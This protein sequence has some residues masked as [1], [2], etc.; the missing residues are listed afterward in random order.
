MS[1]FDNRYGFFTDSGD[2][3]ITDPKTPMPWSHILTNGKFGTVLSQTGSGYSFYQDAQQSLITRWIQDLVHDRYGK[4]LYIKNQDTGEIRSA[5]YKP[6]MAEGEYHIRYSPGLAVYESLFHDYQCSLSLFVP[7]EVDAEIG[8]FT[9][10]N[11]STTPLSLS[12]FTYLEMN[13]GT[14][15]DIHREFHK[16]FFD[17]VYTERLQTL[18]TNKYLWAAGPRHWNDSYPWTVFHGMSAPVHSYDTD[19]R[20]FVGMYGDL[21]DPVAVSNGKCSGSMGRSVDAI[22]ALHTD[23]R[24]QPG[25]EK[26]ITLFTGVGDN[27]SEATAIV[28]KLLDTDPHILQ[29]KTVD[30][31]NALFRRVEVELPP[32]DRDME[33]MINRWLPYQAIAGRIYARTAYYQMG[34]AYGFRDQLQD[35][36]SAL[37]LDPEITRK[38]ILLH[39]NHQRRDGTVQHWWLPL[40]GGF[41]QQRWSD[42]LLWLPLAIAEYI[43][44]TGD[45]SILDVSIP[46]CNEGTASVQEHALVAID[47][48]LG[49]LS[50]RKIPLILDGDW[51][52]GLN[53]LGKNGTG[54]SFWMSEFLFYVI[55][56]VID[57]FDLSSEKRV[58]LQNNALELQEAFN[59]HGWNGKWFDRA[60][61]DNGAVLGG[62][63]D[64]RIFLNPQT[65]AAISGITD[66]SKTEKALAQVKNKLLSDYGPLLFTP[67]LT[68]PDGNIGY[69]SR[70][71]PGS[72]ENGGV[73]THAAV[74]A[75]IA[76][77]EM[78]DAQM[79]DRVFDTLSPARRSS[80]D[81]D[82]YR[83]EPYVMPGNSDGPLSEAP[84]RA[85]WT[86]YT[87]SAGWMY[88]A[89]L[90]S[91]LGIR[92]EKKGF[93][94]QPCTQRSWKKAS[95]RFSLRQGQ[96]TLTI[97]NPSGVPLSANFGIMLDG[98]LLPDRLV[99]DQVGAHTIELVYGS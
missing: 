34:G 5:T 65:W 72:R 67:P 78:G 97:S 81:P 19:K 83:A 26:T 45:R 21:N 52:D 11:P 38:Q 27:L 37:W 59:L 90:E 95:L 33:L 10:I 55:Q 20:A 64:D 16:L 92:P 6:V 66:H 58:R 89:L 84:G 15:N 69:L 1:R 18:F 29:K 13:M 8:V 31:W 25:E 76:G 43:R 86:W 32:E 80:K 74:W 70:Y 24:L 60:T 87:G 93:R 3:V 51:N 77:A 42:D 63:S 40:T 22:N 96:Y 28:Q 57:V 44:F 75:L 12:I 98:N 82:L 54:E 53:G 62:S 39:A 9:I 46:Y 79:V 68:Q 47:S 91:L 36:L 71:A 48:A 88:R 85:G 23:I 30:Q 61:D 41:P 7:F 35:S 50:P 73:Y 14:S 99:P 94:I 2:F 56:R 4:Y 49:A 17:T